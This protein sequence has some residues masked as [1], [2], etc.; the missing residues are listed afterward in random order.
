MAHNIEM[1][2]GKAQMA[3]AGETPWHSLGTKVPADLTPAQMMEKAGLDWKVNKQPMFFRHEGDLH[4]V[5]GKEVLVR[6]TDGK[7]LD[8]VGK[9]WEPVQNAEAFDFFNDFVMNGDMDMHTAGSL[10]EGKQTWALAKVKDGFKVF[11]DDE[12]E[13]YLMFSN[14]HKFGASITVSFTPIRVV[15]NNTLN[16][17]LQGA[18]GKGVRISHRTKFDADQVKTLLG[19]ATEQLQTYKETAEFL[20]S[21]RFNDDTMKEYFARV[22]PN[23]NRQAKDKDALS[24]TAKI[25]MD[26]VHTQPGA[27]YAEGSFWQLFNATTFMTDHIVG[28]DADSRM[29]SAWFG[30]NQTKK[31]KALDT[32]VAMAEAV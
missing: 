6:D 32:A 31:L 8:V 3:Y 25:A 24:R 26:V 22:F 15:C 29:A 28:R 17:A 4:A 19:V 2:D 5:E 12:V 7:V 16:M 13:S 11:G 14:P 30:L 21:K 1:I 23:T 18:N 10:Q 9:G 20:G 27:E